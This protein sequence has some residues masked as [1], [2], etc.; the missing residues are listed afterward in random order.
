MF[1]HSAIIEQNAS[2]YHGHFYALIKKKSNRMPLKL[3][4]FLQILD[5]N[6]WHRNGYLTKGLKRGSVVY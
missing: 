2:L 4:A 5:V 1:I 3:I 6:N